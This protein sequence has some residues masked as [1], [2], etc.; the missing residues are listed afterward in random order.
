MEYA[1]D[2]DELVNP[3]SDA[4]E[5]LRWHWGEVYEI[6]IHEGEWRARRRDGLGGWITAPSDDELSKEILADYMLKPVPRPPLEP[7]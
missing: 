7:S 1:S 5:A 2:D 3:P 6:E 4:L